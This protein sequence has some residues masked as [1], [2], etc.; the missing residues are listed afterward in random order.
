MCRSPA[1]TH[2][3]RYTGGSSF[4]PSYSF[5][6]LFPSNPLPRSQATALMP[7]V[8]VPC[9]ALCSVIS[10]CTSPYGTTP[11]SFSSTNCSLPLFFC[12]RERKRE[13]DRGIEPFLPSIQS[14]WKFACKWLGHRCNRHYL[15]ILLIKHF[16][17]CCR[18]LAPLRLTADC[19]CSF[20]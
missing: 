13:K 6:L 20:M 15:L 11:A 14:K 2:R 8:I 19:S 4:C 7:R 10:A 18:I 16:S 3:V 5:F 17:H 12:V 9:S 1:P